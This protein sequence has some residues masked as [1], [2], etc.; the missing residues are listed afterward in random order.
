VA[1]IEKQSCSLEQLFGNLTPVVN[2]PT[3][4]RGAIYSEPGLGKTYAGIELAQRITPPE[5]AIVYV[6]TGTNWDSFKDVPELCQRV[7]KKPYTTMDELVAFVE[8]FQSAEVRAKFPVGTIVFDEHNTM[9]DDDMNTIP[10]SMLPFSGK[11]RGS[12]KTPIHLNGLTVIWLNT[13]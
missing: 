2:E 9:F 11:K 5:K 4:F 7:L 8:K 13:I 12:T 3:N 1:P 6:Y 10:Q